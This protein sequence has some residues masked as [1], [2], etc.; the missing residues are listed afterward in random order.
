MDRR[1]FISAVAASLSATPLEALAQPRQRVR[2]GYLTPVGQAASTALLAP[3]SDALRELGYV[4][5]QAVSFEVRAAH[6]DLDRLPRMAEELV[7]AKVD[8]ILA[9]S[10]PAILA[11]KRATKTIPIVMAFWGGPGLIE[12]GTIASFARPGTNVTGVYMLGA[13][14]EAKRLE[15][16]LQ[17]LLGAR[18]I[19]VLNPGPGGEAELLAEL[20]PVAQAAK[21][22]LH[23]TQISGSKGYG[24]VFETMSAD[25]VDAVL[26]PSFPRFYIERSQIIEA[27]AR[28]RI[29]AMYEWGDMARA[30]G[31]MAYGPVF[32]ELYR[33]IG[34]YVDHI[35]KGAKPADLPVEQPS[36]FEF[37]IN[38]K[39][40]KALGLTIPQSLLLRADEVIQ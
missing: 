10:P 31:L 16:L 3:L 6:D 30:G 27:A 7:D 4:G 35:L 22:E 34:L 21:V 24:S 1:T 19:A 33:R 15:L 13:E 36:E 17:G 20:R 40:A 39:T 25:R 2:I 29:P 5:G 26:V 23:L 11:A 14:L 8:I 38:L 37:I 9:V 32:V 12:S 28:Q 18:R